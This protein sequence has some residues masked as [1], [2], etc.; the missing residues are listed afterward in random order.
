MFKTS[1]KQKRGKHTNIFQNIKQL[2]LTI[3]MFVDMI[4]FGMNRLL[5]IALLPIYGKVYGTKSKY[6]NAM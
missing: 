4:C 3:L 6:L 5:L 2:M 1:N